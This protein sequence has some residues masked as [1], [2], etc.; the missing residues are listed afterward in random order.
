MFSVRCSFHIS[1]RSLQYQNFATFRA[2]TFWRA[3]DRGDYTLQFLDNTLSQAAFVFLFFLKLNSR[4]R[5]TE[6]EKKLLG[7]YFYRVLLR[8]PLKDLGLD[9]DLK[10]NVVC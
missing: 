1:G 7:F 9:S 4:E 6:G 2:K 3:Q 10:E 8:N 5:K